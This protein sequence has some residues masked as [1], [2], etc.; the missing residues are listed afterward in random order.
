MGHA[1]GFLGV[2]VDGLRK[3]DSAA[4]SVLDYRFI[5]LMNTKASE[6]DP[7][8][9]HYI[10]YNYCSVSIMTQENKVCAISFFPL[11]T[12]ELF[13]FKQRKYWL[14]LKN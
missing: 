14:Q 11:T 7:V 8:M 9:A 1:Q 2:T 6:V 3:R 5:T 12:S 4:P 10:K 13:F